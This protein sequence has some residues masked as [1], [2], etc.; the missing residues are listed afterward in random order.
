[1]TLMKRITLCFPPFLFLFFLPAAHAVNLANPVVAIFGSFAGT[2]GR[3]D[4]F[5][6]EALDGED[7][8][9]SVR[10][11]NSGSGGYGLSPDVPP[12]SNVALLDGYRNTPADADNPGISDRFSERDLAS[13][14]PAERDFYPADDGGMVFRATF[15]GAKTS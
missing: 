10:V 6:L 4:D 2:E 1:M 11:I 5:T 15:G 14:K 13:G 7:I 9:T 12:G 3:F 8:E